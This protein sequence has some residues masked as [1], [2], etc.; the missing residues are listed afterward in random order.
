MVITGSNFEKVLLETLILANF[1]MCFSR[2]NT[3]LAISQEWLDR[4]IWNDKE[5]HWL[6]TGYNMWS[7]PFTSPM[8]LTL[9]VSRSNCEKDLS[10]ISRSQ[11]EIALSTELDDRLTWNEKDVS[12]PL[13]N[14]ILTSVTMVGWADVPDSD[15]GYFRRQRAFNIS[16]YQKRFHLHCGLLHNLCPRPIV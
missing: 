10:E 2:S 4:L 11:S 8:T 7:W 12:H 13:M 14:M 1:L 15:W 16:S 5:V 9:E 6:D 3:I